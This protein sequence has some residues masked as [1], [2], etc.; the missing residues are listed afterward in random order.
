MPNNIV[1]IVK[2]L[3]LYPTEEEWFEFKENWYQADG[4]GEYISSLSNAAA[5]KGEDNGYLVWGVNNETH[6]FTGTSF[7]FRKD[8]DHEPLEHYLARNITPDVNFRF[9][10]C[11]VDGRRI[12]IL[13]IPAA[14]TTPTAFKNV[15]YIRIGSS[16][17]NLMKYP[18]REAALF[19]VLNFG[20]PSIETM[21]S[22]YQDLTFEQLFVYYGVKG[23]TL[24]KRTFKKN[25]GLLT[26]DGKYNFLARLLSDNPHIPIRFSLFNGKTKAS[27][28][29][30]VREF[31]NMCL[32]MSLD[33]VL[34]YGEVLN[35]PQ[36]DERDRVVTRKEVMLFDIGAYREAVINAFVHNL[37]VTEN[38]PMFTVYEDR[39][40]ILSRGTLPPSQTIEG[41]FAGESV[42]VNKKLSE[43][44]LQ[45]HIS[46]KSGRGVPKII[47]KYGKEAFDFRQNSIV[48]TIPFDRLDLGTGLGENPQVNPQVIPQ[49]GEQFQNDD[50]ASKIIDF[51]SVARSRQELMDFLKYK[52]RKTLRKRLKPLIEQGRIAM[53]IPDKPNSS[54]QKYIAIK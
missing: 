3:V 28:M 14:K 21:E 1:Q 12:V 40:E 24:N 8:V 25:L 46:E 23:I 39:I 36:A 48:V 54:K 4:I 20:L 49:V 11:S 22:E 16:K 38:E 15:R 42:P 37:W 7:D 13:I 6:E 18:E 27:T 19:R 33:R 53:T 31:G 51:C 35:V 9:E 43:I 10:E 30:A 45:L 32:L 41:F 29:Y 47:E 5:M 17:A 26:P 52:D 44:F 50:V 2:D 34:E